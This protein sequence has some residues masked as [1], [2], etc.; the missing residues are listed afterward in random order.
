VFGDPSMKLFS[1][2]YYL[3]KKYDSTVWTSGG[4]PIT[5]E[6]AVF[7]MDSYE[8]DSDKIIA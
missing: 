4:S 3:L 5:N 6:F 7:N 1:E 2:L 8:K